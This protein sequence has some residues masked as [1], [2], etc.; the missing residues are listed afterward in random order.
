M[1]R[2]VLRGIPQPT[3]PPVWEGKCVC[4]NC[5]VKADYVP[6]KPGRCYRCVLGVTP[7]GRKWNADREKIELYKTAI[8]EIE[9]E[10]LSQQNASL[11]HG[12]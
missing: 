7:E 1:R 3:A 8:R 6:T 2:L 9:A 4:C 10:K 11:S 12:D 5:Y